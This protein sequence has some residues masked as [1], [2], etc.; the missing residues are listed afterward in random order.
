MNLNG[1]V[2]LVTGSAH[3]VGRAIALG[4][5]RAGAHQVIH[6]GGSAAAAGQTRDEIAA[7]GVEAIT[8]PANLSDPAQ[9]DE[10]FDAI[11]EHFGRLDILVNSAATFVHEP[12]DAVTAETWDAVLTVNLRAPFLC[13]QRAARLMR[14]VERDTP[15]LIVNISDLSGVQPWQNFV[16]HG[17]AKA[18]LLHLTAIAAR[19]LAPD[20][21]V[22]ALIPGAILP[23]PGMDESGERWQQMIEGVPLR[24]SA[25]LDEVVQAVLSFAANDFVTGSLT[26]LDGG[27]HLLGPVN[28]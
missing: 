11:E 7:L 24:R 20:V 18:G 10:L 21:R 16:Q 23:P 5:A 8:V 14:A 6:Y 26:Y 13:S 4:L 22:N 19:E 3:R 9:I 25:T 12:F 15:A 17:V 28:H 2:A 27:E 1:K